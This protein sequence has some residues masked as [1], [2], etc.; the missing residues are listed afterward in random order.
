MNGCRHSVRFFQKTKQVPENV[1]KEIMATSL[2]CPSWCNS[3]SWSA[4]VASGK[5]LEEIRE[6]WIQ[7]NKEGIKG[8]ADIDPEHRTKSSQRSQNCMN[9][10][11]KDV[12]EFLKDPNMKDF[13]ECQHFLFNAPTIVY[14]TLNKKYIQYS[15][16]D[17]GGFA[18]AIQLAAKSHGVDS[19]IA[20]ETIKYPDVVKKYCKIPE[21]ENLVIGIALGYEDDNNFNKFR[22]KK[23]E[24]DEA[25]HFFN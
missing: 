21:D 7:K 4:Y 5:T 24:L 8:Y 9:Q 20:F 12:A 15:V 23:L 11:F 14:L 17:L 16:L 2:K 19:I 6:I 13:A 22:A 10:L 18:M 25:C 1:L 3:Q